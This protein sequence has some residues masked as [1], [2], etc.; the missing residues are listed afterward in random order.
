MTPEK[1]LTKH[2]FPNTPAGDRM[3]RDLLKV[4]ATQD[5]ETKNA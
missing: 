4:L 1:F 3:M 2:G 5:K